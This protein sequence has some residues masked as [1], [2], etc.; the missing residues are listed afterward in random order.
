[1]CTS[2]TRPTRCR[3]CRR[4]RYALPEV[5]LVIAVQVRL[6]GLAVGLDTA[7]LQLCLDVGVL[8]AV[9]CG[10]QGQHPVGMGHHVVDDRAGFDVAGPTHQLRDAEAALRGQAF[11]TLEGMIA[12]L[13]PG[14]LL[15]A[16]VRGPDDD[17]VVG[18]LQFVELVEQYTRHIVELGHAVGENAV[19]RLALVL[20]IEMCPVYSQKRSA[21]MYNENVCAR[22]SLT[23]LKHR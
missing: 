20:L 1:M 10:Q 14:E 19:T 17:G 21:T 16:V 12:A 3:R 18:D 7:F 5:V 6:E 15:G 11:F 23:I 13:R 4:W 22:L 9:G 8:A 2:G